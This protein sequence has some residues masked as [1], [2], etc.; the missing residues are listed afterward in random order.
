[1][2]FTSLPHNQT[3]WLPI[4]HNTS[5]ETSAHRQ[6]QASDI[7]VLICYGLIAVIG[8]VCNG[9]TIAVMARNPTLHTI[10]NKLLLNL[11]AADLISNIFS[12]AKI[13]IILSVNQS[14][15][16]S[17]LFAEIVCRLFTTIIYFCILL[18]VVTLTAI[19][20]E[21]YFGIVKPLVHRNMTP[22][23]LTYFVV[24]AWIS[25]LVAPAIIS[26]QMEMDKTT[27][28]CF[29]RPN[30]EDWPQ[31]KMVLGWVGL[32]CA[33]IIPLIVITVV[34][35]KIIMHMRRRNRRV[36][37]ATA[38]NPQSELLARRKTSKL[39]RLLL[40]ITVLFSVSLLPEIVYFAMILTDIRYIDAA[41]F[42]KVGVPTVAINAINP[43]IYTLS[44]S[45]F[46]IAAAR[47]I[48]RRSRRVRPVTERRTRG[49]TTKTK[50][51]ASSHTAK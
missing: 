48:R 5:S 12:I 4:A 47:L 6:I 37:L 11:A 17:D 22:K 45:T 21:R 28:Y 35:V 40:L 3:N 51:T 13:I 33:Y 8:F 39:V 38:G 15:G 27:Y 2:A 25:S 20:L 1:M 24:F 46:R 32:T 34:Y 30:A 36:N 41:L 19:A 42:Y 16:I 26:E 49:W 23:R 31:W 43:L 50:T 29:L 9:I 18:S 7:P 14:G 10:Y 44:N